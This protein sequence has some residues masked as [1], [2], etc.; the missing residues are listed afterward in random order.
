MSEQQVIVVRGV[1]EVGD[2]AGDES[3]KKGRSTAL[4]RLRRYLPGQIV[5]LP[6][7]EAAR[8]QALGIVRAI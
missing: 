1:V 4:P 7:I 6:S 8:L 5:T 3:H 2:D